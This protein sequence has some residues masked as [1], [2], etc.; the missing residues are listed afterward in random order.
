[1][2]IDIRAHRRRKTNPLY[3]IRTILRCRQ[4]KITDR[5]RPRIDKAIAGD[6]RHAEGLLA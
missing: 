4:E 2:E 6:E 5:Q 3:G 1:M